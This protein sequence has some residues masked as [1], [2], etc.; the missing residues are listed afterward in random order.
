MTRL[1]YITIC[2]AAIC[3]LFSFSISTSTSNKA[4]GSAIYQKEEG[5][6]VNGDNDKYRVVY[7]GTSGVGLG[8][9]IVFIASDHEYRS[10][11]SL[12]ALAKILAK[13]YGFTCTVLWALDDKDYILPGSSNLHGLDVLDNADLMVIFTRFSDF[14]DEEM[15][16][17]DKYLKRGGPVVGF[18]TATHAFNIKNHPQWGHYDFAYNGPMKEWHKGFGKLVLGETWVGHYGTNHKQATKLVID[19]AQ[20][21][22]PIMRGVKNPWAQ[23]GAYEVYPEEMNATVLARCEV[24]NGMTPDSP[25]DV[26]KKPLAAAWVRDYQL[27]EGKMGRAFA[28]VHGASEDLLSKDFRRMAINAIFWAA[29]MEA[30]IKPN[31]NIDFVGPYK[32]TTFNFDGYKAN[33]KP[34]DLAGWNS[35]IMPGKVV[36]KKK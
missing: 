25:V 12:P 21:Q 16:H 13:R 31:S 19:E 14:D 15:Q 18:R 8:K 33:V 26:T 27:P 5:Y 10:E 22:H 23:S 24:L 30:Q 7:K 32:P 1:F 6:I 17:I 3:F 28:T 20:K 29:G 2:F 34:S 35:L 11:E 36:E 4:N 9:N